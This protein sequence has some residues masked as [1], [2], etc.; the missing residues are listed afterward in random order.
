MK[1]MLNSSHTSMR[2]E[3]EIKQERFTSERQKLVVNII[4]TY[5][6]LTSRIKS[7]LK[8]YD[9]TMQQFNVL[10]ILRGQYPKP[11]TLNLLRDR[12][13]DKQSDISRLLDRL[14]KKLLIVRKP[15]TSDRRKM[16]V[17]ISQKGLDLLAQMD[18]KM[19]EMEKFTDLLDEKEVAEI[20]RL[21]DDLRG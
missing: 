21:M 14:E 11:S 3:E 9:V 4:Y 16:D 20:N 1:P 15:S 13:L 18:P 5:N 8:E 6:W 19:A 10:R 7:F 17:L 12:M 2:L